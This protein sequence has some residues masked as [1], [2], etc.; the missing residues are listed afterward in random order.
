M[1][2]K[3]RKNITSLIPSPFQDSFPPTFGRKKRDNMPLS[4]FPFPSLQPVKN[5]IHPPF[6]FLHPSCFLSYQDCINLLR[7]HNQNKCDNVLWQNIFTFP[8]NFKKKSSTPHDY[9]SSCT[10]Q[11]LLHLGMPN[12][13]F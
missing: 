1:E 8:L 6:S 4:S 5:S 7:C 11:R 2:G 13:L 12:I 3:I 9:I 10:Y